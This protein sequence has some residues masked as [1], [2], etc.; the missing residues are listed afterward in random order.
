M[1]RGEEVG[2]RRQPAQIQSNREVGVNPLGTLATACPAA[3]LRHR[4]DLW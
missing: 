3:L 4:C 2:A 1:G